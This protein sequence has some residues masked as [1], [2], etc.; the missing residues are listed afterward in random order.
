[1]RIRRCA[2]GEVAYD[3]LRC[4]F[5]RSSEGKLLITVYSTRSEGSEPGNNGAERA[6]DQERSSGLCDVP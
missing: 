6:T 3:S 4:E 1:M 2:K 5:M